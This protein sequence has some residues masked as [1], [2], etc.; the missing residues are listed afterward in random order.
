[1]HDGGDH[2]ISA[3][4]EDKLDAALG[5]TTMA[6]FG[7]TRGNRLAAGWP[8]LATGGHHTISSDEQLATT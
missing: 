3:V 4:V 1:M 6:D 7:P 8:A 5:N 2:T